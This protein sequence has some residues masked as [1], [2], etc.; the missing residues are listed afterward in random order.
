MDGSRN[1]VTL[2]TAP[3]YG[4][5]TETD[6]Q[7]EDIE[8][9]QQDLRFQLGMNNFRLED[10]FILNDRDNRDYFQI[11]G[12]PQKRLNEL[13]IHLLKDLR[14]S[15]H[16]DKGKQLLK[17]VFGKIS[18]FNGLMK[19]K[20]LMGEDGRAFV[21][22][23]SAPSIYPE[24]HFSLNIGY[25]KKVEDT[26]DKLMFIKTPCL[27]DTL[28]TGI[29]SSGTVLTYYSPSF[30][31]VGHELVHCLNYLEAFQESTVEADL[32]RNIDLNTCVTNY[33]KWYEENYPESY[34][35]VEEMN[36]NV[37]PEQFAL[38]VLLLYAKNK[39]CKAYDLNDGRKKKLFEDL[40]EGDDDKTE[41]QVSWSGVP[42]SVHAY[43]E[44]LAIIG[45]GDNH[46]VCENDLIYDVLKNKENYT[47]SLPD[48]F[49]NEAFVRVT[50]TGEIRSAATLKNRTMKAFVIGVI[51]KLNDKHVPWAKNFPSA[52]RYDYC[53]IQ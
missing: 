34:H 12:D 19:I 9:L 33:K 5:L 10:Y 16:G 4:P 51:A 45:V 31:A 11:L 38:Q 27:S 36:N 32:K 20:V 14:N 41:T 39:I 18:A 44:G 6:S 53:E 2:W 24:Y 49:P 3:I 15:A 52:P 25:L 17:A 22:M 28:F 46:S 47:D 23:K 40:I 48:E 37:A 50:H 1:N 29:N 42:K 43:I 26:D 21:R 30:L 35:L 8:S 7:R 13:K